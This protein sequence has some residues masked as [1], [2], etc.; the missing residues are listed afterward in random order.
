MTLPLES[1]PGWI[2][3]AHSSF[4]I[5]RKRLRSA[6]CIPGQILRPAPYLNAVDESVSQYFSH[7]EGGS[8]VN[9]LTP[10]DP[11]YQVRLR[12]AQEQAPSHLRNVLG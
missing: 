5:P 11:A 1:K 2:S 3:R 6:R 4:A 8:R 7:A 12:L 10:N 9:V